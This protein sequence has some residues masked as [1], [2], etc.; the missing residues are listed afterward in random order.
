V[1]AL[2]I[3]G[4]FPETHADQLDENRS[5]ADRINILARGGMPIYAECGGLMYLGEQLILESKRYA[6]TGVFPIV[7]GLS[8]RPQ[9]HGY[10]IVR[11]EGSNPFFKTGAQIK[12]HEFH[13]S[14]VEQWDGSDADMTFSMERGT[15]FMGGRDGLC[16]HNVLASYTHIHALGTPQWAP[17]LVAR[18]QL[19]RNSRLH[20][21]R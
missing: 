15:G 8:K 2:Y 6:M 19:Y 18:A 7:F 12:G 3:G 17:A 5:Y 11:I 4:G 13:Y 9:G 10:T 21:T 16:R 1:D 20:P 14:T